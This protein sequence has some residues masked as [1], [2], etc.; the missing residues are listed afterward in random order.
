MYHSTSMVPSEVFVGAIAML[1][2]FSGSSC[3]STS[4]RS[5]EYGRVDVLES[6][7]ALDLACANSLSGS[8]TIEARWNESGASSR[9]SS[10]S[11]FFSG[12]S[13][14]STCASPKEGASALFPRARSSLS[15]GFRRASFYMLAKRYAS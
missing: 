4:K 10:I 11:S 13:A 14:G 8:V 12:S 7:D 9:A 3:C 5:R 6:T 2:D 15:S 1:F